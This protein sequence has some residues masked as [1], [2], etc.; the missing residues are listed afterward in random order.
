MGVKLKR[1]KRRNLLLSIIY[2]LSNLVFS[3]SKNRLKLF[4]DLEWIFNRLSHEESFKYYSDENHPLRVFSIN[5]IL[6]KIKSKDIVIDIGCKYGEIANNLAV[7]AQKV[8]AIDYDSRAIEIAKR[9]FQKFNLEFVC[10]D[11]YE[12]LGKQNEHY[13]VLILSHLLEHLDEPEKFLNNFKQFFK[14][15]Y[16]ELPDFDN[17]Y[18]NHYR[19]D[20]KAELIYSDSDHIYEF[21]R[22]ELT[23]LIEDCGLKITSSEYRF[24]VQ[25]VWCET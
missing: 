1:L 15:I 12:Y 6:N 22:A 10:E 2:R 25:R 14:R 16:I 3:N 18:L 11:A 4:T 7:K 19:K 17:S 21:D 8:I 13:D 24:G 9:K 5:Y 23:R 20:I